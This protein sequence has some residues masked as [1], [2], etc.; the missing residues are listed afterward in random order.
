FSP[1]A[2]CS[3]WSRSDQSLT[4]NERLRPAA[5]RSLSFLVDVWV[6]WPAGR[7]ERGSGRA[8]PLSGHPTPRRAHEPAGRARGTA[9]SPGRWRRWPWHWRHA[10]AA[11]LRAHLRGGRTA[12]RRSA[13]TRLDTAIPTDP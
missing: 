6:S 12:R 7:A 4:K 2:T 1:R 3:P 11:R 10:Y 13:G 9:G 5:G 8:P